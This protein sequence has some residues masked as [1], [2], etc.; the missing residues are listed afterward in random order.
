MVKESAIFDT[1]HFVRADF[2]LFYFDK[3][4]KASFA[5]LSDRAL[6]DVAH[7]DEAEFDKTTSTSP[8]RFEYTRFD[9]TNPIFE[10]FKK[11]MSQSLT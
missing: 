4:D 6:F 10:S 7:F 9:V 5:E 2:D 8:P 3:F 1:G 11:Q